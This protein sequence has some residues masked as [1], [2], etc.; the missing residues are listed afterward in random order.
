MT[1]KVKIHG[2]E[3]KTVALR[4]AEFRATHPDYTISTDLVE[5]ND[6][7]VIMKA[8]ILDDE[9][10]LLATGYAE[11]VRAASKINATSALENAETSAIGR[12]LSALGFGGQEY[13][14]A[15]EVA[16]AIQQQNDATPLMEHNEALQ[17]N[18][19]SVYFIKEHLAL[20]SWEAVAEAWGEITNDDK[21]ALWLAP[22]KG[23]IF[24]TA[25]RKDLKSDEFNQA[26]KLILGEAA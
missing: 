14:S 9:G 21:K 18:Y 6:V 17:R 13:A 20:Q 24:T 5:A 12:C 10:R 7:L 2:K 8:S 23:G 26:R 11:E 25:E 19:A 3:Y 4:V 22:S 15:D 1:G 16:N